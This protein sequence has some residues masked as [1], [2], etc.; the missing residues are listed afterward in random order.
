MLSKNCNRYNRYSCP[1]YNQSENWKK[2]KMEFRQ[3][4]F[5]IDTI[6]N[7]SGRTLS[8]YDLIHHGTLS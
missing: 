6:F 3:N 4:I 7:L 5:L 2:R 1:Q 8:T